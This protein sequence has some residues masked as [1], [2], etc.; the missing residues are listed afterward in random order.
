MV[1]CV[2]CCIHHWLRHLL[3][4]DTS[5]VAGLLVFICWRCS[6][7]PLLWRTYC[8]HIQ[9]WRYRQL[10]KRLLCLITHHW[11]WSCYGLSKCPDHIARA[12]TT[13]MSVPSHKDIWCQ[14]LIDIFTPVGCLNPI[15]FIYSLYHLVFYI[16][17]LNL[18]SD[19]VL[20]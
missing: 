11:S 1:K 18:V 9:G 8:L 17:V 6:W 7:V 15:H 12:S 19:N 20:V 13:K 16:G 14:E 2:L 5:R 10:L 3:I 4:S